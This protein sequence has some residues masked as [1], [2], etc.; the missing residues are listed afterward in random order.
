[1]TKQRKSAGERKGVDDIKKNRRP[2]IHSNVS[3]AGV[4]MDR[5]GGKNA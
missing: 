4:V 2:E 5:L 3:G 1:M